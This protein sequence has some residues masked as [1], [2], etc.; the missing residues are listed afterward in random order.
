VHPAP[1]R[2]TAELLRCQLREIAH[3][4]TR[5]REFGIE[6]EADLD[7]ILDLHTKFHLLLFPTA[8]AVARVAHVTSITDSAWLLV[9]RAAARVRS[10]AAC[11]A[12]GGRVGLD[13]FVTIAVD[14]EEGRSPTSVRSSSGASHGSSV[15]HAVPRAGRDT[16]PHAPAPA[17]APVAAAT[18]SVPANMSSKL[19]TLESRMSEAQLKTLQVSASEH[20]SSLSLS[21]SPTHTPLSRCGGRSVVLRVC[22]QCGRPARRRHTLSSR[23]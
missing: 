19:S 10:H 14:A 13:A 2:I 7:D 11:R 20:S 16:A 22:R 4:A 23:R 15:A 3:N 8:D 12:A 1:T 9:S 6:P 5:A 21:L 17:P 18:A